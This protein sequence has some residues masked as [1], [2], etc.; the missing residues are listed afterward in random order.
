MKVVTWILAAVFVVMVMMLAGCGTRPVVPAVPETSTSI[1]FD[2][3]LLEECPD[4]PL[5]VDARDIGLKDNGEKVFQ[6]YASC[7]A[8]KRALNQ[9]VKKAF[10]IKP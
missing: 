7:R 9:E 3:R 2:K 4:L 1:D 6:L 10:N 5:A 8:S